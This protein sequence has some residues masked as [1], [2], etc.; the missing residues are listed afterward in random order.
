MKRFSFER[1]DAGTVL[2]LALC[3]AL[4]FPGLGDLPFYTRGEPREALQVWEQ[5]Q[6]GDWILPLMNGREIPAK[7]PLFHWA[8]GLASLALGRVDELSVR[9]PSAI[10]ATFAVMLVFWIGLRRWGVVAGLFAVAILATSFEWLRSA[11]HARVDM[12]FVACLTAAY[13]ALDRVLTDR[14]P[15]AGPLLGLYVSMGF[16]ALAKGPAGFL[17]PGMVTFVF[18]LAS[19]DL[20]RLRKMRLV[21]GGILTLAIAGTWYLAA[22]STGGDSFV[23]QHLWKENFGRFLAAGPSGAGHGHPWYYMIAA[24]FAGYMPWSPLV[25]PLGVWL[26]EKRQRL[27]EENLLLPLVW[28]VSILVFFTISDGKRFVYLLPLYPAVGLLLGAWSADLTRSG[29]QASRVVELA[30]QAGALALGAI[31]LTLTGLMAGEQ[32]GFSPLSFLSSILP[33]KDAPNVAI[34]QGV[35][36]ERFPILAVS[37]AVFSLLLGGF[38]VSVRARSWPAT[39]VILVACVGLCM[40]LV[41]T[42]FEPAIASARTLKPFMMLVREQVAPQDSLVFYDTH[43]YS[44]L[45]YYG[46][47]IPLVEAIPA[48]IPD[49]GNLYVLLWNRIWADLPEQDRRSLKVISRSTGRPGAKQHLVFALVSPRL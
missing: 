41:R 7:P 19:R 43:D 1:K 9:L 11:T 3:G 39:V 47:H 4:F 38:H 5:V 26:W 18:L 13:T 22:I 17:L 28:S 15:R 42:V 32:L 34:I 12:V 20:S 16:A 45:F 25:V 6:S 24:F 49:E 31:L 29:A 48:T 21:S 10:S 33:E 8:A 36:D 27:A 40:T 2:V 35:I 44:A 37:L 46:G 14:N 23:L 30:L